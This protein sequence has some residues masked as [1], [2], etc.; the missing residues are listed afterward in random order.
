MFT[1][2]AVILSVGALAAA[3]SLSDLTPSCN[4]AVTALASNAE[5]NNC[6]NVNGLLNLLVVPA[7]SSLIQPIDSFLRGFCAAPDC[8]PA[9]ISAVATNLTTA[10]AQDLANVGVTQADVAQ[11]GSLVGQFFPLVK[12]VA[13]L[14]DSK[15]NAFCLTEVLTNVQTFIGQ[16]LS[17]STLENTLPQLIG[18][19]ITTGG[20]SIQIPANITC[21][22]CVQAAY[23]ILKDAFPNQV[24][25]TDE[26]NAIVQQCGAAFEAADAMPSGIDEGTGANV[27]SANKP[28]D[29]RS[30]A[31]AGAGA[32]LFAIAGVF[33]AI[34]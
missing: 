8:D 24:N 23:V 14:A 3:Q 20:S 34:A 22:P 15:A 1:L 16:P 26:K 21:T 25:G 2:T 7:N 9:T 29:A 5:V 31:V 18:Q 13:C 27:P 10:C 30:T 4:Q 32:L 28:N 12:D 6:T 19:A 11:V 33:V 17:I